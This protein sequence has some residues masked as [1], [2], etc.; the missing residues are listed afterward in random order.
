M[1]ELFKNIISTGY[2][3]DVEMIYDAIAKSRL[4]KRRFGRWPYR[5]VEM[6]SCYKAKENKLFVQ[7]IL[8]H[9]L[10]KY[11]DTI[12]SRLQKLGLLLIDIAHHFFNYYRVKGWTIEE[13]NI[14]QWLFQYWQVLLEELLGPNGRPL[15]HVV[16]AGHLLQDIQR[17]GH[18]DVYW[19]FPHKQVV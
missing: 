6:H 4:H 2:M 10:R 1:L 8:P 17:F 5:P 11:H 18:S 19:C 13:M 12:S 14:I 7:W 15:E 16:R 3:T 9:I